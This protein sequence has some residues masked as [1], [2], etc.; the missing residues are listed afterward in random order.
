MDRRS[1]L[2]S[3]SILVGGALSS[4]AIAAMMSGC[5]TETSDTWT[6]RFFSADQA[7]LFAEVAETIIPKTDTPGAKDIMIERWVDSVLMDLKEEEFQKE[8]VTGLEGIEAASQKDNNKSFLDATAE[9]RT[10]TLMTL[11]K[12]RADYKGEERHPFHAVKEIV[13]TAFFSSKAGVTQVIQINQNPG[14]YVGCM[15]LAEAGTGKNWASTF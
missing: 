6:P 8:V 1:A 4:G 11:D 3:V 14:K 7:K 12:A 15:P 5:Q 9:E 10:A 2:K 13:L